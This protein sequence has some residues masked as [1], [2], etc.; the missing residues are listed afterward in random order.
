[1]A[2]SGSLTQ[3]ISEHA[4]FLLEAVSAALHDEDGFDGAPGFL[5]NYGIRFHGHNF[6]GDVGF[7]RPVGFD[8]DGEIAMGLP[9][10]N[11]TYRA[12]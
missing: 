2:Y 1:L 8:D 5:L 4:K 6:A 7:M 12:N 9:F 3:K 10:V 11:F